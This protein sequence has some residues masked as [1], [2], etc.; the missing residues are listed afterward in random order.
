MED[1]DPT[2]F[3]GCSKLE[4]IADEGTTAYEF[5]KRF[6]RSDVRNVESQDSKNF[7]NNIKEINENNS[8]INEY[9]PS[10]GYIDALKDPSNVEWMPSVSSFITDDDPSLFSKTIVVNGRAVL[11]IN[12]DMPVSDL[13]K[14]ES[15]NNIESNT[16]S[17]V[18]YNSGKGGYLPKYTETDDAIA[19]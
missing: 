12:K 8:D 4:I 6:E 11:F 3:D 16:T 18:I 9:I 10:N 7:I 5:Y 1:I 19:A 2:A 13:T 17:D 14:M 15:S